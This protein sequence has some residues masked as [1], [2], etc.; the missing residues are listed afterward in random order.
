MTRTPEPRKILQEMEEVSRKQGDDKKN[1]DIQSA[2]SQSRPSSP[3]Q[4]EVNKEMTLIVSRQRHMHAQTC[5]MKKNTYVECGS[6]LIH[7]P[8]FLSSSSFLSLLLLLFFLF[9]LFSFPSFLFFSPA[10][11]LLSS[12]FFSFPLFFSSS[13]LFFLLLFI[14]FSF[15]L[16]LLLSLSTFHFFAVW[17]RQRQ[18]TGEW[19]RRSA[20]GE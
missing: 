1:A 12:S 17:Q 7:V 18:V 5:T 6:S 9:L 13:P 4:Q 14:L 20:T 10:L 11:F 15:L 2:S 8:F 3:P 16:L 19:W